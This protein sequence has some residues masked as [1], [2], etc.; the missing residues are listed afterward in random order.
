MSFGSATRDSVHTS[1][2]TLLSDHDRRT[3][4]PVSTSAPDSVS[5]GTP[6][7]K[8]ATT[9][10][11]PALAMSG[12]AQ[13]DHLPDSLAHGRSEAVLL[14]GQGAHRKTSSRD[15]GVVGVRQ[16]PETPC[17]ESASAIK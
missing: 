4:R 16:A 1:S 15:V 17:H 10:L 11:Q 8:P 12:P 5:S 14:G 2:D 7:H 13:Q 6:G 9:Q 3:Q